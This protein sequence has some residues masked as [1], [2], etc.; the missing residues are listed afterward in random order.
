[1]KQYCINLFYSFLFTIIC[2]SSTF[3]EQSDGEKRLS[4]EFTNASV[5]EILDELTRVTGICIFAN[6]I[7]EGKKVSKAYRNLTIEQIVKDLFKESSFAIIWY[8]GQPGDRRLDI[9]VYNSGVP[10][11]GSYSSREQQTYQLPPNRPVS[12]PRFNKKAQNEEEKPEDTETVQEV[13][14]ET[15]EEPERPQPTDDDDS[16]EEENSG[17]NDNQQTMTKV[18]EAEA[19]S[20]FAE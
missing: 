12:P 18:G 11:S 5:S 13:E 15:D 1:M 7:P 16:A 19:E 17:K 14:S 8:D 10:S 3:G 4:L 6:K 20:D 9:R 2:V